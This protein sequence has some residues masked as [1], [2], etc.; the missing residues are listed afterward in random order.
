ML[1]LFCSELFGG[2][3]VE[4]VDC[5]CCVIGSSMM[6]WFCSGFF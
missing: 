3:V 2:V 5:G 4:W 1:A 6:V